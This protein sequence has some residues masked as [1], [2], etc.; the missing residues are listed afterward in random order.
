MGIYEQGT[1]P[2]K[3]EEKQRIKGIR[4]CSDIYDNVLMPD[5]F[6]EIRPKANLNVSEI[7]DG[8]LHTKIIGDII[9][10]EDYNVTMDDTGI[11]Q[12]Q[13]TDS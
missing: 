8:T 12:N 5:G 7:K 9:V 6:V 3:T 11:S 10:G 13:E 1:T 4:F 2:P